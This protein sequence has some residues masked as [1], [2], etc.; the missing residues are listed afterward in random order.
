[1]TTKYYLDR[2]G[3]KIPIPVSNNR[4]LEQ[5]F[6]CAWGRCI[7]RIASSRAVSCL[8]RIGLS[9]HV[10]ALFISGFVRKNR[11]PLREYE[12]KRYRSF[13]EFFMRQIRPKARPLC[14]G[15]DILMSPCDCKASV[16]AID[17]DA[18]F[19]VKG[20]SY[21]VSE[22]LKDERLALEYLGGWFF[23]L[24]LCVEDYH[25]YAYPVSGEKSKDVCIE[26]KL[27]TVHPL[28]H[29]YEKVYRENTRRYCT[30]T[31]EKNTKV[32]MMEVGALGVGKI[33]N[34]CPA[35][36]SVRQGE[37]KGHFEF[38]GSTIL[39]LVPPHA[40]VPCKELLA[41]TEA[42]FETIVKLGESIAY[43]EHT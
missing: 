39:L 37:E 34:D 13:H 30:I 19:F 5:L 17:R 11:I 9:T 16:Y 35:S 33:V 10:S 25:H 2:S 7:L 8:Q 21:T 24:R 29:K 27:Y 38:G 14:L 26:G 23:L 1:M 15:E 41:H 32:L 4:L 31:T 22:I 36:A 18:A 6:S 43:E 42:G 20:V 28:I 3:K 12:R 40:Y